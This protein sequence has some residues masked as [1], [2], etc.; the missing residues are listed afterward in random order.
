MHLSPPHHQQHIPPYYFTSHPPFSS[1]SPSLFYSLSL[2][3]M[4]ST[5]SSV[6]TPHCATECQEAQKS[7]FTFQSEDAEVDVRE[8]DI[9]RDRQRDRRARDRAFR[10]SCPDNSM[11]FG[12]RTPTSEPGYMG[13]WQNCDANLLFRMS[14]QVSASFL[15]F[16]ACRNELGDFIGSDNVCDNVCS[17]FFVFCPFLLLFW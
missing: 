16:F 14:Q 3:E 7:T 13:A 4:Q 17:E 1:S 2:N 8:R 15:T 9:L 11:Q 5:C 10:D 12:R 6:T